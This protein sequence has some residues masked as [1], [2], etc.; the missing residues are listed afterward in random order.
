[1]TISCMMRADRTKRRH[2]F[3]QM[4]IVVTYDTPFSSG[5]N[6]ARLRTSIARLDS[7]VTSAMDS[8]AVGKL[9]GT[10]NEDHA[11]AA[12]TILGDTIVII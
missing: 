6:T 9:T 2:E 3:V 7:A 1:M 11:R 12:I 8:L 10:K 5:A 4:S